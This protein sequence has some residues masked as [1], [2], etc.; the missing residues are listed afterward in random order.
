[1]MMWYP[2]FFDLPWLA[3]ANANL[4]SGCWSVPPANFYQG[5][6]KLHIAFA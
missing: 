2:K 5:T 4:A 1:M 6:R 3:K